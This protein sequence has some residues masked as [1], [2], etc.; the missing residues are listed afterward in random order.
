MA[1]L[2]L[3]SFQCWNLTKI[4]KKTKEFVNEMRTVLYAHILKGYCDYLICSFA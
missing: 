1:P 4:L 2:S 3:Y